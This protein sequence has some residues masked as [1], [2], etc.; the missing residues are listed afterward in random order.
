[1]A[2]EDQRPPSGSIKASHLAYNLERDPRL[3]GALCKAPWARAQP[4][5]LGTSLGS[6]TGL[7]QRIR[8]LSTESTDGQGN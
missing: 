2:G 8:S 5:A 1:M 6:V 4:K 3:P 7:A